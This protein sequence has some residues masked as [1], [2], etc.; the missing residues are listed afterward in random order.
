MD[1]DVCDAFCWDDFHIRQHPE[2]PFWHIHLCS[3][4]AYLQDYRELAAILTA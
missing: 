2:N 3:R 1:C 4:C